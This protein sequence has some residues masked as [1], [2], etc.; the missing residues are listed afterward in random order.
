MEGGRG[1]ECAKFFPNPW[2]RLAVTAGEERK[3]GED[4]QESCCCGLEAGFRAVAGEK[5]IDNN[6]DKVIVLRGPPCCLR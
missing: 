3:S 1:G 6:G 4:F 5:I 2:L